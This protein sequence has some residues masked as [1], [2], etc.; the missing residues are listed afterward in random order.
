LTF[1]TSHSPAWDRATFSSSG[2]TMRHGPHQAAQ[3]STTRGIALVDAA[4]S[5]AAAEGDSTGSPGAGSIDLHLAQRVRLSSAAYARRFDVP[6]DGHGMMTPRSSRPTF[7]VHILR[8]RPRADR[9]RSLISR[10]ET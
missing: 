1:N 8:R 6:Q 5:N 3:K 9:P 10:E 7:M 4:A 2:A